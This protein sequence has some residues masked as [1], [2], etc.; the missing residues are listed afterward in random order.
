VL[1]KKFLLIVIC[2]YT[3]IG[4]NAQDTLQISGTIISSKTATP[5]AFAK[6]YNN[7]FTVGTVTAED[8]SFVLDHLHQD[9]TLFIKYVGYATEQLPLAD[10]KN[11]D[12]IVLIENDN[13]LN[14]VDVYSDDPF[15]YELI[16]ASKKKKNLRT[17]T[18]K[19]YLFVESKSDDKTIE[20]LEGYYNGS[21][22]G[23]DVKELDLKAGRIGVSPTDQ[24][25]VVS[26][27]TSKAILKH[28]LFEESSLFPDNP[29]CL[30]KRKLIKSY[31][32]LLQSKYLDKANHTIYEIR[33]LPRDNKSAFFEGKVWIDSNSTDLLR[34]EL[35]A[36]N[37]TVHPF[38]THGSARSIE[39]LNLSINKEFETQ[40][41]E[42]F[43]S[44]VDFN[45]SY[46]MHSLNG[47]FYDIETKALLSA[48]DFQSAYDLPFFELED[49]IYQDYSEIS[50]FPKNDFFWNNSFNFQL[51]KESTRVQ[52]F[53]ENEAKLTNVNMFRPNAYQDKGFM[54]CE[55][56]Q[57]SLNRIMLKPRPIPTDNFSRSNR[58]SYESNKYSLSVQIFMDVNE[59]NDSLHVLTSTVFDPFNS[60]FFVEINGASLAFLNMYF[61]FVEVY[62]RELHDKLSQLS[63]KEEVIFEYNKA[64]TDLENL[65]FNFQK[66]CQHGTS[67][68]GMIKW[69]NYIREKTGIDNLDTFNV[70]FK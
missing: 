34:I 12:T 56:V 16:L 67:K 43:I 14:K 60:Y 48:F 6:V 7:R 59:S 32:L 28:N 46:Q 18:A 33:F 44:L 11:G 35:L 68:V 22:K 19:S 66:D 20:M 61:D 26:T 24:N 53:I 49:A 69:N 9:D 65:S 25:F 1:K 27:E 15:L 8:G 52:D 3:A 31:R 37:A 55:Y 38:T 42:L 62:R 41:E 13:L 10:Y 40:K 54:D 50:A 58:I 23:Y 4:L 36:E 39:S 70:N 29:F 45:Y 17:A 63:S 47:R 64:M 5:L 51:R 57:W 2:L 21:Y 30:K